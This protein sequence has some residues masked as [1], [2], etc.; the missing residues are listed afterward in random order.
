MKNKKIIII[1]LVLCLS[2]IA[3]GIGIYKY[4]NVGSIEL[5]GKG[6]NRLDNHGNTILTIQKNKD[7]TPVSLYLYDDGTYE[8]FTEYDSCKPFRSCTMQLHYT[9]SVKGNY[10]FDI[11]SILDNSID[12]VNNHVDEKD[13]DYL[14]FPITNNNDILDEKYNSNYV[15][16]KGEKNASLDDLLNELELDLDLCAIPNYK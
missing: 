6:T 7:C 10:D 13:I 1:T 15:I 16:K 11:T 14:L 2:T 5:K 8:Y 3:S 9:K 4:Y 12:N